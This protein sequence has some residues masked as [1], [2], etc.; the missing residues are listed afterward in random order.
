MKTTFQEISFSVEQDGRCEITAFNETMK[1]IKTPKIIFEDHEVSFSE[2]KVTQTPYKSGVGE[3][4]LNHYISKSF[5][6]ETL[7]WIEYST[8]HLFFELIPLQFEENFKEIQWPSAFDFEEKRND[9]ITLLPHMQGLMIPNDFENECR[10]LHF[11]G[12]WCSNGSYMPWFGQIRKDV[13]SIMI[14]LTPWDG[15]T[16]VDHP[17]QGPYT[18]VH[19]V[20]LPSMG[21]LSYR[22]IMKLVIQNEATIVSLCKIYRQFVLEKGQLVTLKQKAARNPYV[23]KLIGCAFLHK[24]IKTHVSKD[25]VFYDP[26][27]PEKNDIVIPFSTRKKEIEYLH[28]KGIEKLYLHLDGWGNPGYDNQ[29]P[30]YLP[31][32]LEAG[33]YEGM[34]ELSD[35]LRKYG[36]MFGIH[37]QYRDYYMDA[38]TFD[39]RF[40]ITYPDGSIFEQCQW[41]GGRQSYLCATQAPYY[42]KRNFEEL[43]S[44][45]I[46]LEAAYLDV[47]TCN[48]PDECYHLEHK[49]S[50]KECLE[51][52]MACFDYLHSK[53]IL[54]SS[55]ECSDWAMK[56]L[57]FAHYGPYDFMLEKP[58]TP[59]KGIPVPLFNLVYHDCLILPWPMDAFENCEDYMLYALLN[60]GAAYVDKEGAYPNTDGSFD[61][62]REKALEEEIRRYQIVAKLQKE[63]AKCEM[64]DFGFIDNNYSK[65]YS[66]FS[67]GTRVEI[68]LKENTYQII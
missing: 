67:N 8:H 35:T 44:H 63:V 31:P 21:T 4:I 33:G 29:H 26:D 53:N 68:N 48:E 52:R 25:S 14:S 2:L 37:D 39:R 60:G 27:H 7:V 57:V 30:D 58:N 13:G 49:M 19:F 1:S 61:E 47:F 45:D 5:S 22:R 6:F 65:Q 28:E 64:V 42:V 59:K 10:N 62:A 66:V 15:K 11:D 17:S 36:D 46:H 16:R 40:G 20:H 56:S 50:R 9:W 43:L 38:K 18:H 23:D 51:Y 32:C 34:K 3:G 55:E 24:G 12:Q 41:A 54:P